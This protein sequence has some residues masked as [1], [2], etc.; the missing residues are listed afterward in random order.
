MGPIPISASTADDRAMTKSESLAAQ[1]GPLSLRRRMAFAAGVCQ[2]A[3]PVFAL[4]RGATPIATF[5]GAL[6]DLGEAIRGGRPGGAAG[7]YEALTQVVESSCDDTLS[8]EW[9]AWL[10]LATFEYP[11][12]LPSAVRPIETLAQCSAFGLTIMAEIDARAGW[13]GNAYGGPLATAEWRAQERC[14]SILLRAPTDDS[15]PMDELLAAGDEVVAGVEASAGELAA[16]TG[17]ELRSQAAMLTATSGAMRRPNQLR[18]EADQRGN[19][20]REGG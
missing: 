9:L 13:Q 15:I 8:R 2:R 3:R 11:C 6:A 17:W 7:I 16:A 5:D 19:D 18:N 12:A 1:M 4:C 10:A 20:Q 14:M